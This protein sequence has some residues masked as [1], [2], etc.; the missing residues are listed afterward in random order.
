MCPESKSDGCTRLRPQGFQGSVAAQT[1]VFCLART[2]ESTCP[3]WSPGR[4]ADIR[5]S[6]LM[7]TSLQPWQRHSLTPFDFYNHRMSPL[8]STWV[9]THRILLR[10]SPV[11]KIRTNWLSV[12]AAWK[13]AVFS[14][15]KK[16]SGTQISLMYSAPTTSLSKP[17]FRSNDNLGSCQNC[18]KYMSSVK[19]WKKTPL[20]DCYN[21][22]S[23]IWKAF[24]D[25][26]LFWFFLVCCICQVWIL[27]HSQWLTIMQYKDII[28]R[29]NFLHQSHP[30][31][32]LYSKL[33]REQARRVS[34]CTERKQKKQN[35]KQRLKIYQAQEK[36]KIA[37]NGKGKGKFLC[38]TL[39]CG[40]M[41]ENCADKCQ[42]LQVFFQLCFLSGR[43]TAVKTFVHI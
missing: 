19:S 40:T 36:A 28:K 43:A 25:K 6:L 22:S 31:N 35:E 15:T 32:S 41:K 2:A 27:K 12:V 7:H 21:L 14:F 1:P 34:S 30:D 8:A 39:I 38:K 29:G 4:N 42:L 9:G 23:Q 24:D 33:T 17:G 3:L 26:N 10:M 5:T 11:W 20:L 37:H 16:V 18:R 13:Y